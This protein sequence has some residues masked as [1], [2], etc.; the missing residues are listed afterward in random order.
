MNI[1]NLNIKPK[2]A[3][4]AFAGVL[5]TATLTGCGNYTIFDTQYT[6]N[7]A[8]IFGENSVTIV[9]IAKWTDYEGE[10]LQLETKD[11]AFILTSSFDT[12]LIDDRN[13][14]ITAEYLARSI[15]GEDVEIKYLN[16]TYEK[17]K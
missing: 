2:L 11:G 9:E 12:K 6:F 7:K 10:Q 5:A 15:K 16:D 1:K 3:A 17:S 8:L 13:S 4:M 14:Y